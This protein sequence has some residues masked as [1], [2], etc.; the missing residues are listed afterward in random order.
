MSAPR[1]RGRLLEAGLEVGLG[2]AVLV[3]GRAAQQDGR[4]A[5]AAEDLLA[6]AL[7]PGQREVGVADGAGEVLGACHAPRIGGRARRLEAAARRAAGALLGAAA[8]ALAAGA[9]GCGF[10]RPAELAWELES[11]R[12]VDGMPVLVAVRDADPDRAGAAIDAAFAEA[13]RVAALLRADR[14]ASEIDVLN[15]VPAHVPIEVSGTTAAALETALELAERTESAYD[16]TAASLRALWGLDDDEP[17][18]PR[19]FEMA[20][21]LRNVDWTLVEVAAEGRDVRRLSRRVRVDLGP[22]ATGAVLDA[23]LATLREAGVAAGRTGTDHLDAVFGGTRRVPWEVPVLAFDGDATPVAEVT[24]RE[25]ALATA[26]PA[27]RWQVDG[28]TLHGIFDPRTGEPATGLRTASALASSAAEA[29]GLARALFVMG[30]Q[31]RAYAEERMPGGALLV[32]GNGEA[33]HS[34]GLDVDW[35][36]PR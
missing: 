21:A 23:A 12:Q 4:S 31:A 24:L 32:E 18:V 22:V 10:W 3:R 20:A 2:L 34:D 7:V 36:E 33:W 15:R 11:E 5:D 35:V 16:P 27:R 13:R 28:R 9:P 29:G 19:A 1:R 6:G 26:R 17:R 30:E 14:E 8:V 25:G